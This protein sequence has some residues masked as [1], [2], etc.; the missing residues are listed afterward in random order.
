MIYDE[1]KARVCEKLD[2]Q[3]QH[4]VELYLDD[5]KTM[6]EKLELLE[7]MLMV[8]DVIETEVQSGRLVLQN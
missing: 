5:K 3:G 6:Q 7:F 4:E 8:I 1:L 2:A